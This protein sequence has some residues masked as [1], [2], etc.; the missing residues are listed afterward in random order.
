M[1]TVGRRTP[2]GSISFKICGILLAMGATTAAAVAIALVV[3]ATLSGSVDN[4]MRTALPGMQASMEVIER[5]GVTRDALGEMSQSG[6]ESDLS[7]SSARL[8][9]EIDALTAAVRNLPPASAD[10]IAPMLDRLGIASETMQSAM[11]ARFQSSA[12]MASQI[13]E[14]SEIAEATRGRLAEMSDDAVF[15][16]TIGGEDT[17][18]TV[19]GTL[20]SLTDTE[21]PTIQAA[22][23]TRAEINLVTGLALALVQNSDPAF[24]SILRDVAEG[25]LQR[26]E[27]AL[28]QLQ[29]REELADQ[30]APIVDA[31]DTLSTLAGRSFI[32]RSGLQED[33]LALRQNSD[34][35]LSELI[36]TLSFDL[37]IL[38][39]DTANA[40]E[41]AIRTLL[42]RDVGRLR[43][44]AEVESVVNSVFVTA[45]LG[46]SAETLATVEGVQA[47]LNEAA[48]Q[49]AALTE[50][51]DL[52]E[53]VKTMLAQV[54]AMSDPKTGLLSA[55]HAYL[56]AAANAMERSADAAEV[57][58]VIAQAARAEGA[59]A[60]G[61]IGEAGGTVLNETEAASSQMYLIGFVSLVIFLMA[62]VMTW[63]LILRPMKRVTEVTERLATGDLSPVTGFEK[64]GG[65]IG[66][67]ASALAIFRDGLIERHEMREQEKAREAKRL[68]DERLAAEE[69]SRKEAEE[70]E[71]EARRAEA[72]RAREAAEA[73]RKAEL[74]RE[75]QAERDARAAEQALV[76][77][78]LAGGLNRLASGDLTAM[79]DT[80]FPG[81]YDG[82]RKNYNAA[83]IAIADLIRNLTVSASSVKESSD[84][85]ASA[86][87]QMAR[88]TEE[89]AASLEETAAAVNQLE[90][91]ACRMSETAHNANDVMA[92]ARR[93][94][95]D[96]RTSV[97]SAVA[98]MTEIEASSCEISKI[99]DM[100]ESI[101][102]QTNLLA[103]NAGV[104]AA[105]A[106]EQGRGFAVVATEVRTLAQRASDAAREINEL[107]SST[108]D[109]ISR[110]VLQ[111][112]EAGTALG[113]I[114]QFIGQISGDIETIAA[115]S[116]EQASTVSEINSATSNLDNAMQSNAAMFEESL[117]TSELLRAT[118]AELLTLAKQ[119]RVDD[120]AEDPSADY[121]K[122]A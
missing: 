12:R 40:N 5:S 14:F 46:A 28:S 9:A 3:F 81:T 88:R 113:G 7:A 68:E 63:A 117:A 53:D 55:R 47:R 11:A 59:A 21:F 30:L 17:L 80:E 97:E 98:T 51:A 13:E 82:L 34:A 62:P 49:L 84:E 50:T 27:R 86:A 39:E 23:D 77:D 95:E 43:E 109:Q 99:V 121:L 25:S 32:R 20:G 4:L 67:M 58:T 70:R 91:S 71:K 26:L 16:L 104:E 122:S 114:L 87:K 96:T 94:A 103:L 52:G 66:R 41:E 15:D 90:A 33:L 10:H 108:R 100:I 112:N 72:D 78:S 31:H 42:E 74:E 18:E 106:G 45:L 89:N 38:A 93:E 35:V 54:G 36:D 6:S 107:I 102:F 110:G 60:L 56:A 24:A 120:G 115:G 116:K 119:F 118:S 92:G 101:A 61:V 83:V 1:K 111:V 69:A 75:A 79:I 57:L 44:A 105:R 65:E 73:A 19:R 37:V 29:A 8:R 2:F 22:L 76:V 64:T 85:I 48:K